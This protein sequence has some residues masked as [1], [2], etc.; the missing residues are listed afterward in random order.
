MKSDWIFDRQEELE[1]LRQRF[2]GGKSFLFHGA[3]GLGKSLLLQQLR[4]DLPRLLYSPET[5]SSQAMFRNLANALISARDP[6]LIQ[7]LGR[8]AEKMLAGKSAIS[9]KGMV[10]DSLRSRSYIVVIDHLQRPS[11]AFAAAVRELLGWAHTPVVAVAN[12]AHMEDAGYLMEF[13]PDRSEKYQLQPFEPVKARSFLDLAVQRAGLQAENLNEFL[14][15]V[16]E[17]SRGNPGS[18]LRLLEMAR[19]PKYLS[20]DHILIAPLYIDYR[21][22]W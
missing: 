17:V 13:Y 9:L 5:G 4:P 16:L 19:R 12:S 22:N 8:T 6:L 1:A 18:I 7:R 15:R 3:S 2:L 11:Q 21:L 10:V 20:G 14:E